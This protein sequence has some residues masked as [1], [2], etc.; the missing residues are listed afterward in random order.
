[1]LTNAN[2]SPDVLPVTID[3]TA[4]EI[5]ALCQ[6]HS[7][8]CG[9]PEDLAGLL[10][11]LGRNKLL[12]LEF[13]SLIARVTDRDPSAAINDSLLAAIVEAVT[14]QTLAEA[15]SAGSTER[16]LVRKFANMLAGEDIHAPLA[17][18]LF[19][20]ARESAREPVAP[21]PGSPFKPGDKPRLV[22]QPEPQ[23]TAAR[24]PNRTSGS[25]PHIAIP[26][27]AY[28]HAD[29]GPNAAPRIIALAVLLAAIAGAAFALHRNPDA[30]TRAA[31]AIRTA[32]ASTTAALKSHA[33]PKASTAPAE[34][35][36]SAS[37]V[38][39]Q[40]TEPS[41]APVAVLPP[42]QHHESPAAPAKEPADES[43]SNAPLVVV[44][45]ALMKQ[46]LISSRVPVFPET[47]DAHGRVVLEAVIT[48]RG[49]VEH[50]R[51]TEGDPA[52]RRAAIDAAS[53]W[54]YHP[55]LLNGTPA[56]VS[57]TITVDFAGND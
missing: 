32:A 41:P 44:P 23:S 53:T 25:E 39:L 31:N 26:L 30:F 19:S 45:E 17:P 4:R 49:T 1:M 56:D 55:Y 36:A 42:A 24:D 9:T 54:R 50:L 51:A 2:P 11:A 12:A 22:L 47:G 18:G 10:D 7:V 46:N 16:L 20:A 38:P 29:A 40:Q 37:P 13:W 14:S 27:A 5:A 33:S 43:T 35:S 15:N 3:Q 28:A 48:S 34:P 57:T 52:L 8:P 6:K 21:E